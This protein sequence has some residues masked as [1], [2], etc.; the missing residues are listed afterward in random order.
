MTRLI[1][2]AALVLALPAQAHSSNHGHSHGHSHSHSHAHDHAQPHAADDGTRYRLLVSDAREGRV[3][4][5]DIGES[6]FVQLDLAAPATLYPGPD[7]RHVWAVQRGAG[8]VRLIDSGYRIEDH[9]DHSAVVLHEPGLLDV[10]LT[11]EVPVHF[12]M[13]GG[14]A[15]IFWDGTGTATLHDARATAAGQ[16]VPLTVFETGKPHHGV[17]VPV[18]DAT[19]L[20]VAPEGPGLPDILALV[21]PEGAE[22]SRI[23]CLN[24]HGEGKAGAFIAFGCEDG[25]AI[26]DTATSPVSARFV[27]YPADA[28]AGGMIRQLLSPATTLAMVG[29]FGADHLTILDPSA[30]DGDFVFVPLPAA[31]MAFALNDTGETGFAILSDGQVV[32]FSALTGQVQTYRDGVTGAYSMDRGVI[33]PALSVTGDRIAVSDPGTGTVVLL[34]ADDLEVI[35]R[36][37]VGGQPQS[38]ILL[39][40]EP[41]HDH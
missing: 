41:D 30:A 34:D 26:F 31:R 10:T 36:I 1:L 17:A 24:L 21:G 33:R 35:E 15:A 25:V 27:P 37:A 38:L 40:A 23:D 28:P 7:G 2:T 39:A 11:G 3:T 22:I 16:A 18:G 6:E 19:I 20:T 8:Q 32:R 12:N 4:I 13:G 5:A 29:S 9:G 14:R